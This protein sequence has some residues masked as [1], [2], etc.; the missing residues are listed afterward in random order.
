[1]SLRVENYQPLLSQAT[2]AIT[3]AAENGARVINMSFGFGVPYAPMEAAIN[4]AADNYNCVLVAAAGNYGTDVDHNPEKKNVRYPAAYDKVIAV[5]A[6]TE[7]DIRKELSD[8]TDEG[9][10]GSCYAYS[11]GGEDPRPLDVM[12]PG[13]HIQTT[14]ITGSAGR[15]PGNYYSSF[16]GTSSAAP[17]VSGLAALILS[18]NAN[19]SWSE[20]RDIIRNTADEVPAMGGENF[21]DEYG[22]GRINVY[23]ALSAV[24]P[25][26]AVPVNFHK[27]LHSIRG[28]WNPIL[29]WSPNSEPDL[30]GYQLYRKFV[31]GSWHMRAQLSSTQT[32]FTDGEIFIS[33]SGGN[34]EYVHYKVRAFSDCY[35]S[36]FTN[37]LVVRHNEL[38]GF[39]QIAG[40]PTEVLPDQFTLHQNFPNPFNPSTTI[41][42]DLPEASDI[43][44]I[45]YTITG[46]TVASVIKT[47]ISA[48]FR[49]VQWDG[50]DVS[51]KLVPSG[52]YFYHLEARA[53]ETG[54]TF[55]QS[56]KMVLIR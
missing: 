36:D 7:G 22:Y 15:D 2:E 29:V 54:K 32:S 25:S 50:T 3:Y 14:D 53:I 1:M 35:Y 42:F 8:G 55:Q 24:E 39:K 47:A 31:P 9:N 48:G 41:S 52:I 37:S 49:E 33:A 27:E 43:H 40:E 51:G 56:R 30:A 21:T 38:G 6:T 12:A 28:G 16:S 45:I 11:Y 44:L 34:I 17:I 18:I 13:I 5:G 26:P 10:W 23:A 20:V 19:L 46:E 4:N